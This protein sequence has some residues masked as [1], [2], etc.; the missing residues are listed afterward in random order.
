VKDNTIKI[1]SFN[2]QR[3]HN[4]GIL[5]QDLSILITNL[6]EKEGDFIL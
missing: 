2:T 6:L 4:L 1:I 3:D 5:K